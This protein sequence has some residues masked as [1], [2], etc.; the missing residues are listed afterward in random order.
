M[1][2]VDEIQSRRNFNCYKIDY[3][4]EYSLPGLNPQLLIETSFIVKAFPS[5][6]KK[7]SSM[8]YD[9]LKDIKKEKVIKQYE[10]QEFDIQVQTIDRTFVDKVFALCDYML[11]NKP[12]KHSRHIYD[13]SRLLTCVTLNDDLK[14]LI[15]EV[16]E[17]RKQGT[18]CYS[19]QDDVNIPGLL[20][21]IID[22]EFFKKDYEE[23]TIKILSNIIKYDESIKSLESIILSNVFE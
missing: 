23:I 13:L 5:E 22:T 19:A 3:Q 18:K 4:T 16:R 11:D 21:K 1:I 12:E 14:K 7:A 6:M 15:K 8:I 9:F 2:N 17:E 10:L 20:R